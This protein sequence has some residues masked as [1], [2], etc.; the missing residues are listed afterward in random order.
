MNRLRLTALSGAAVLA[1]G[2]AACGDSGSTGSSSSSDGSQVSGTIR[3]DGSSTVGPLTEAAAEA[4]QGENSEVRVTVGTSGTGGGFEKFCAG[5][6]DI[7]DA[8]REIEDDEIAAC[9]EK[10]I[11]YEAFQVANDGISVVVNPEND[12]AQC[13]TV[14]QL[15]TIWNTG[16]KVDNWN[17][18]DPS[19]PDQELALYGPGTDSGTFDFFT[20]KINGEE[21]ASRSDYN[22]TEDDNVT[23]QGVSG[24]K[25]GL[26]YFGL[27][28]LEQNRDSIKGIEVDG[29]RGC[30]APSTETVQDGTYTPL[31]RPLFIY[32]KGSSLRKP[33][34]E[35]FVQYYVD[36][37]ATLA[38][39][40][41][42]V[43]LTQAQQDELQP[44]LDALK[45]GT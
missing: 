38:E 5:E 31:S 37:A 35:A 40:A 7:S 6:T 10:G 2:L 1:L 4:F 23:V 21:G 41:L 20:D 34:V 29:G 44:K 3:I 30:V 33:E 8:S 17:Q 25:G 12:W 28:Y 18:I 36:N 11:T 15:R 22:A 42:F 9:R 45:S 43:P 13:L 27:S 39:Q 32:V 19:F 14:E 26:G 24:D 16:S